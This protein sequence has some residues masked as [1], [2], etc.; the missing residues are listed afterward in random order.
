[1]WQGETQLSP[2]YDY[3]EV[4][5]SIYY[6]ECIGGTQTIAK[7]IESAAERGDDGKGE[8]YTRLIQARKFDPVNGNTFIY[9][10]KLS[11]GLMDA[12]R[13]ALADAAA[14][15]GIWENGV[16]IIFKGYN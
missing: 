2:P 11:E 14:Y 12:I 6:K 1:M 15:G 4:N 5:D 3:V 16:P 8:G 13:K 10:L 7:G 9:L